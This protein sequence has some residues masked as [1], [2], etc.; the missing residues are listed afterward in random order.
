M[1]VSLRKPGYLDIGGGYSFRPMRVGMV[2][3]NPAG[4]EIYVQP[5]DATAEMLDTIA[6]LDE[7]SEDV[8][9]AKR[10]TIADMAL[11]DYF[12]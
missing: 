4:T 7:V 8:T 1:S 5:G 9:D 3:C 12:S 2:V 11:G 10:G 6:A